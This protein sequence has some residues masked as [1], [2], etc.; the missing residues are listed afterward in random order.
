MSTLS[1]ENDLAQFDKAFT[2]HKTQHPRTLLGQVRMLILQPR[3]FFRT[4]APSNSQLWVVA[5]I[6]IL[7]FIGASAVRQEAL[8]GTDGSS[9][10]FTASSDSGLSPDISATWTP[11]LIATSK[12]VANW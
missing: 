12:V 8:G 7:G 2:P 9:S 3:L 10:A 11:V 1:T 6:V 5:A 4:L